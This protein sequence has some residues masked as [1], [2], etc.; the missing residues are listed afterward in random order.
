MWV[1]AKSVGV[2]TVG[3]DHSCHTK[4]PLTGRG[5]RVQGKD[6]GKNERRHSGRETR[7][8]EIRC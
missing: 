5:E 6:K 3:S 2:R 7:A 8:N 1:Q 4:Q